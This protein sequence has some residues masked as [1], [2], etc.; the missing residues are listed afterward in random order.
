MCFFTIDFA[1]LALCWFLGSSS[2]T[3]GALPADITTRLAEV[4]SVPSSAEPSHPSSPHLDD[5]EVCQETAMF[6]SDAR[7]P[8]S[9]A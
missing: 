4:E 5:H 1:V 6:C 7:L 9:L 8:Y 3:D 2:P